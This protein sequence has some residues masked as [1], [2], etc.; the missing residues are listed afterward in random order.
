M[1]VYTIEF[2]NLKGDVFNITLS[3]SADNIFEALFKADSFFVHPVIDPE[4][5]VIN[6]STD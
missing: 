6:C 3:V 4:N 1:K 2:N 5:V